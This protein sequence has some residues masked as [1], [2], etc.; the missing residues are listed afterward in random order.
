MSNKKIKAL[1]LDRDG[2]INIDHGFV[3]RKEQFE[4]IEGVFEACKKFQT[5]GY[6]IFVVTNQSGI[7][8]GYYTINQFEKLTHWMCE[9]FSFNGVH[10]TAVYYCPHHPSSGYY[11]YVQVCKCRKPSPG[12]LIQAIEKY[13]IDPSLSIMVGDSI[14]DMQ[15]AFAAGVGFRVLIQSEKPLNSE[16]AMTVTVAHKSLY[17]CSMD[18]S[19]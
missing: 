16:Y 6:K 12:M 3:C 7:A 19:Q 5:K 18:I 15:A 2:V 4:F 14:S 9:Q 10:I 1:F 13:N 8:R 17:A 11:P